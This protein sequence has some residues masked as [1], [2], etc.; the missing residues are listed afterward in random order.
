MQA[1]K[2]NAG[3]LGAKH[4]R[5]EHLLSPEL[6]MSEGEEAA[7]EAVLEAAAA[8]QA[9]ADEAAADA[10]LAAEPLEGQFCFWDHEVGAAWRSKSPVWGIGRVLT[11]RV[12]LSR[13]R[14]S[15]ASGTT[16]WVD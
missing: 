5:M 10:A 15:P 8:M 14:A 11:G 3:Y 13:G 6:Y 4:R 16:R 2:Y 7:A 12:L 1:Q 9:A